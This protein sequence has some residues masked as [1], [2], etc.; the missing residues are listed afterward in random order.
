MRS[1]AGRYGFDMQPLT[2]TRPAF[3]HPFVLSASLSYLVQQRLLILSELIWFL[4]IES[5]LIGKLSGAASS[6]LYTVS[7]FSRSTASFSRSRSLDSCAKLSVSGSLRF[8]ARTLA[9]N[10]SSSQ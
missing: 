7:P 5:M 2:E 3:G 8:S 4:K 10:S 1:R 6:M 9:G